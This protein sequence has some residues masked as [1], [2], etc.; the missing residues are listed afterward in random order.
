MLDGPQSH[1]ASGRL[2][3]STYIAELIEHEK[4]AALEELRV[5]GAID[6]PAV[7]DD[8]V[9]AGDER[10][11]NSNETQKD[12]DNQRAEEIRDEV[13]RDFARWIDDTWTRWA[14][15]ARIIIAA[16]EPVRAAL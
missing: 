13:V 5:A 4:T 2:A 3:L 8:D 15:T 7:T 1:P 12:G 9:L 6:E 14:S 10:D 16:R 11:Q